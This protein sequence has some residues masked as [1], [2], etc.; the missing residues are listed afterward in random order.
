MTDN[1]SGAPGSQPEP[2]EHSGEPA[3]ARTPESTPSHPA[4]P[5]AAPT[6][7]APDATTPDPA[8]EATTPGATPAE[9]QSGPAQPDLTTPP[10]G[11]PNPWAPAAAG[12]HY[13]SYPQSPA[14]GEQQLGAPFAAGYPQGGQP[15]LG[16]PSGDQPTGEQPAAGYP[17]YYPSTGPHTAALPVTGAPARSRR[18][19]GLIIGV[20]VIALVIGG[21]AGSLGGYLFSRGAGSANG[22][23]VNALNQPVQSQPTNAPA[24]SVQAVAGQV[25]PTVVEIAVT[26]S[27]SQQGAEGDTGSGVIISSDGQIL[28]NNHV[29]AGAANGAGT[30]QVVF[31]NGKIV[32][33]TILGRDPTTDIA[34]IKAQNVSGLP[35]AKIGDSGTAAVGQQVIAIGAPFQLAGTVTEGIVSSLHRPVAAGDGSASTQET[36]LDA[37]QTDAAINPGNSGGPLV[38]MSGQV[39]GINSA[40]YSP[41]SAQGGQ[42]S[43]SGNVGIGF[44]IPINQAARIAKQIQAT[45][46]ATQTVL[47]VS[48]ADSVPAGAA[49][50]QQAGCESGAIV[51]NGALIESVTAGGPADKAGLKQNDVVVAADGRQVNSCD[52]LVAA[53]HAAAPGDQMTLTLANGATLTATLSGQPVKLNG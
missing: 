8:A 43:A 33:A 31:A 26:F 27:Q 36:V 25:S 35:T 48:V 11:S 42:G 4:S 52:A 18:P 34:V 30:I 44:A 37:I 12:Y 47:G 21:L 9:A 40:I 19:L 45:G 32:N 23:V 38:N 29:V 28:T 50:G 53:V 20:A 16:Q 51:T 1:T 2:A 39:I 46:Q 3:E 49:A 24:G 13:S 41:S 5:E 15:P 6:G 10:S 14:T 7:A 22:P 17:G